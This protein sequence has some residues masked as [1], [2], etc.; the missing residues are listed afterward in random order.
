MIPKFTAKITTTNSPG[1]YNFLHLPQYEDVRIQRW[2]RTFKPDQKV[3][4]IIKKHVNKRTDPQN[5][6][7]WAV[8]VRMLSAYC[9]YTKDETH[10]ALKYKFASFKPTMS[11]FGSELPRIESTAKMSTERFN[12]YIEE[13]KRWAA[14]DLSMYI[15]DPEEME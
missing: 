7:Y 14:E 12:E 4:I 6:Y 11:S 9:G 3:D 1:W 10:S 8:I 13:I 5:N 2:I 15:P